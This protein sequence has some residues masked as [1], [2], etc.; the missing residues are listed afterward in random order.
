MTFAWYRPVDT[1]GKGAPRYF[2]HLDWDG[3]GSGNNGDVD[4][5]GTVDVF[6]LVLVGS[7]FGESTD[8]AAPA[9]V[10][11]TQQASTLLAP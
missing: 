5:N 2:G 10:I 6:D 1:E 8:T 3:D 4:G 11:N 7:H 9:L